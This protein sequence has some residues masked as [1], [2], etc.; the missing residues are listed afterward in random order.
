[1]STKSLLVLRLL[2]PFI[3]DFDLVNLIGEGTGEFDYFNKRLV[4]NWAGPEHWRFQKT[5]AAP[6]KAAPGKKRERKK[7]EDSFID[8]FAEEE[9]SKSTLRRAKTDATTLSLSVLETPAD[10]ILPPDV[11]YKVEMLT[12]LFTKPEKSVGVSN[13][14]QLFAGNSHFWSSSDELMMYSA[15]M[16][17]RQHS[18]R[19]FQQDRVLI[20]S[21]T[22]EQMIIPRMVL[23]QLSKAVNLS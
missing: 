16:K 12:T 10:T 17:M 2:T 23:L 7:K 4:Q 9:I 1:M 3:A 14:S 13:H 22:W 5:R 21:M 15:I 19:N 11:H 20:H 18:P 8:F 6:S